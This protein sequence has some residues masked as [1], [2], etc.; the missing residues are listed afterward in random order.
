V[1]ALGSTPSDPMLP[2]RHALWILTAATVLRLALGALVPLFPDEAYYWEWSR[3]LAGGYFDHP[4]MIAVLI[5]GG[6]ALLGDTPLG[7]RLLPILAGSIAGFWVARA[8][9]HLA[10]PVAARFAAIVFSVLP[11]SA[12]G[13]VLAT[14]DAPLLAALAWTLY[15]VVRALEMAEEARR[16]T[17]WW[18]I[19]GV[20]IGLAMAS[21][22]TGV[23]Y[24]DPPRAACA[25]RRA[26]ALARG[27]HR[28]ARDGAGAL[29]ERAT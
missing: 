2:W 3:R 22:F 9:C 15:A 17:S 27:R 1:N 11:L 10:G 24:P 4:P 28:V 19:A 7:V 5:A 16:E 14:P 25:H 6:T 21:K 8:A 18:L 12:A 29:V 26:G 13:L 23:F 20:A